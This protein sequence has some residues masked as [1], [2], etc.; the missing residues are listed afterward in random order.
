MRAPH[1]PLLVLLALG[2]LQ[3]REAR[4]LEYASLDEPLARLLRTF[5]PRRKS[6]HPEYPFWYLRNDL[7]WEVPDAS[8]YTLKQGGGSPPRSELLARD[9]RAGF[10][11]EAFRLLD[12]DPTLLREVTQLLLDEHFPESIHDD[13]L[14]AV[15]LD[16]GGWTRRARRDP[17]FRAAVLQAYSRTCAVCGFDGHLSSGPFGLDAAH[18]KWKQAGGPDEVSNGIAMC[19]L[20]HRAF[21]RGAFTIEGDLRLSISADLVGS[22]IHALFLDLHGKSIRPP[23]AQKDFVRAEYLEWHRQ[24]VF[25]QPARGS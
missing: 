19:V 12:A 22:T 16:L 13:I 17:E 15:G 6:Y 23:H 4:L 24:E 21:D 10:T 14:A 1:K 18:V 7:V 5:G 2:R 20:H 11:V 3:R 8:S 9:A 25:L